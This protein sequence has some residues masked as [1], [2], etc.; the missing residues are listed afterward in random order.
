[1]FFKESEND[2][3]CCSCK[4]KEQN[5]H[6]KKTFYNTFETNSTTT[7]GDRKKDVVVTHQVTYSMDPLEH[8]EPIAP[9]YYEKSE[10]VDKLAK[11]FHAG[12]RAH[13]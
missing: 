5:F 13:G 2:P 4:G 8:P 1:M 12:T 3:Q 9:S 11:R 7:T 6:Q 10:E